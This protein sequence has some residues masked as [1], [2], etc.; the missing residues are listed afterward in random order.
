MKPYIRFTFAFLLS[1]SAGTALAQTKTGSLHGVV[2]DSAQRVPLIGA[3]VTVASLFDTVTVI[4]DRQGAFS[5][6]RIRDTLVRTR[7]SYIGYRDFSS[8]V[9]IGPKGTR[10]DTVALGTA[11]YQLEAAVVQGERPLMGQRGDTLIYHAEAIRVLPGDESMQLVLRMPGMEVK[12][13]KITVIGKVVERTYVDGRPLFGENSESALQYLEARDV[14]DIQVY[15]ELVEEE[16]IKNNA[17]GKKRTVMN[18]ITRSKPEKSINV[19]VEGGYGTDLDEGADGRHGER[20]RAGGTYRY[21]SE[22]RSMGVR[23]GTNNSSQGSGYNKNTY[24]SADF[25]KR[26]GKEFFIDGNY[27][28]NNDFNRS[29]SISRQVYFPTEDYQSRTYDDT[30]RTENG[31]QN[32][33]VSLHMRYN[34]KNDFLFFAP[35]ARFSRSVSRSYRGALNMLDGETLNRVATSQRSDGDSYNISENLAWSHAFKEGKHG[36]NLSA[37]GTLS[38]N[39]DDGWQVDSLSSTSDRT[40]LENTAEG[41]NRSVSGG[42][43][44]FYR[45]KEKYSVGVNYHISYENSRSKRLAVDRFTGQVDTSL[46]YD[47]SRNYTTQNYTFNISHFTEKLYFAVNAG[48]RSSRLNKDEAFPD[49]RRDRITFRSFQPSASLN[50]TISPTRRIYVNYSSNAQQPGVE[51][52][53]NELNYQNPLSLSGGNP[54]LKQSNMHSV[55]I[56]YTAAKTEKS[57]TFSLNFNGSVTAREIATKQ[58][59]FT[60]DTPLPEYNGYI[61]PKGATLTTPVNVNGAGSMRLGAGYSLPVKA[62]DITFSA[63]AGCAYSRRPTYIGDEL[64]YTNSLSP[65]LSL[66]LIG[67]KSLVYQFSLYTNTAYNRTS[68]SRKSDNNTINQTVATNLTVNI[69]KKIYV[70]ANYNYSLYHNFSYADGD[71]NTHILN[72]TFGCKLFKKRQGDINI[73]AYDLL[74]RTANFSTSMLADYISYNWTQRS[75]RYLMLNISYKFDKTGKLKKRD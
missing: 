65:N 15:E 75:G 45:F 25:S 48:Y 19:R 6:G 66:S 64:N 2:V 3:T 16:K 8:R 1:L 62:L 72:L 35:N 29:Q 11:D 23:A 49:E 34:T 9:R 44:Y 61:A 28:Y 41:H 54:D 17:N 67:N 71:V 58:V 30:S 59:F 12:D 60:E 68:N 69:V 52:L 4:T 63:N 10:M 57:R 20:Y 14:I 5:I 55:Y 27:S 39:N 56:G 26:W 38:K 50:Y 40:Y 47:Y 13:G 74:N 7:I 21:F 31:S 46:T 42:I 32:H 24:A 33:H 36:F 73:T 37:D 18:L 70:T 43:G 53:R 22:K 51:Q